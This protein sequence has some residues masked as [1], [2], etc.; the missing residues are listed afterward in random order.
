MCNGCDISTNRG[1]NILGD[2][3]EVCIV[4]SNI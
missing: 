1:N 2:K 3:V 4:Y